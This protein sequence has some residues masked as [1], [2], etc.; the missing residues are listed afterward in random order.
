M[1]K[2]VSIMQPY[3]LP[4][5]GY[6]QL[7]AASDVFVSYDDVDYIKGGWINRNRW[8]LGGA[9]SFFNI[10]LVAASS[11]KKINDISISNADVRWR[12]K[13]LK[14]YSLNYSKCHFYDEGLTI[15]QEILDLKDRNIGDFNTSSLKIV[16]KK[17]AIDTDIVLSS[18]L[19]SGADLG[20]SERV[21]EICRSLD[22]S[23]Y[24]NAIGGTLLYKASDFSAHGLDLKFLQSNGTDKPTWSG[25]SILH[26]ITHIGIDAVKELVHNY[27][28]VR[29]ND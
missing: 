13:L 2:T 25:L 18:Q 12:S 14:S 4:Y 17:L 10:P 11:S 1:K 16:A 9:V 22:A 26:D 15:F 24:V 21:R 28:L 3:F 27:D 6:F 5:L 29:P 20:G 23:R 8:S 19:S 7:I